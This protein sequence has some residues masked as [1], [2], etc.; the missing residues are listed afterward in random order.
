[1]FI[2]TCIENGKYV[3]ATREMFQH[4]VSAEAYLKSV[5]KSRNPIVVE[6]TGLRIPSF[7]LKNN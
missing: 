3:L 4:W 2:V 5:S 1:M 6:I 7:R